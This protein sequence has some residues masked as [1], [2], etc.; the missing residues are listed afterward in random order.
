VSAYYVRPDSPYCDQCGG[1]PCV[2]H[3]LRCIECREFV[4]ESE[5]IGTPGEPL[6]RRCL[7]SAQ[8]RLEAA[9]APVDPRDEEEAVFDRLSGLYCPAYVPAPSD[10]EAVYA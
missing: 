1:D 4:P 10:Q 2:C 5:E 7:E 3:K 6:H 8:A 9:F